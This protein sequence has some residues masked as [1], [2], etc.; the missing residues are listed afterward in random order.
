MHDDLDVRRVE[1]F[2][3]AAISIAAL[4]DGRHDDEFTRRVHE[5][6]RASYRM[7]ARYASMTGVSLSDAGIAGKLAEL[8][9]FAGE[10]VGQIAARQ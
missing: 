1:S 8:E 4:A 6:F 2:V 10:R 3:N 7:C 9:R 5:L